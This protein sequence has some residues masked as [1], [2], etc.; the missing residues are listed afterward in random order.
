M[1]EENTGVNDT[2]EAGNDTVVLG[3]ADAVV[4]GSSDTVL[5][6]GNDSVVTNEFSW[7]GYV[8]KIKQSDE[9]LAKTLER[10]SSVDD[11]TKALFEAK[12][13][14]SKGVKEPELP[15]NA[16]E[17]QIKEYR[18][19]VGVP[20]APNEYKFP[21][22]VTV[23]EEDKPLWDLF[24]KFAIENNISQKDFN[25]LAPAYYAMEASI[26][27]QAEKDFKEVT[28]SQDGGIKELWGSDAADNMKAN[29]AFLI[30]A[31]GEELAQMLLGAISADGKPL[32]NNPAVAKWLNEQARQAGYA[33]LMP[34][35]N[36][37]SVDDLNTKIQNLEKMMGDHNS[38]YWKGEHAPAKQEEYRK[39]IS[40]R[41]KITAKK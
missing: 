18:E 28:R 3:N 7:N 34:Y 38:A 25:K 13:L 12:Q 20:T 30:N 37:S 8:E 10:Y 15:K 27:E 24:G 40:L 31:G 17:E 9:K 29:E 21:E 19:K 14:I 36:Q 4:T 11:V 5:S 35:N 6:S 23:K 39:L 22:G 26:R 1:T 2:V 33:D 16:T 32:G 41:D